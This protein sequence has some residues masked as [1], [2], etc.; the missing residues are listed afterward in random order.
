MRLIPDIKKCDYCG[1]E[2]VLVTG[3]KIYPNI[4][5]LA[6][7]F[8]WECE[9]CNAYIGCHLGTDVPFGGLANKELRLKRRDAHVALDYIWKE[10]YMTRHKT[11][12][13]LAGELNIPF[14]DCHI[15]MFDIPKCEK[16]ILLCN[17]KRFQ[18]ERRP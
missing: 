2:A 7:H 5:D 10:S 17:E 11:Y 4:K 15:G 16:T 9:S 18:F 1:N 3:E 12:G 13:W 14:D 6:S 8:F